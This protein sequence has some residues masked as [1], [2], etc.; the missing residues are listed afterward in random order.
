[1][2]YCTS[3]TFRKFAIPKRVLSAAIVHLAVPNTDETR[4]IRCIITR[5]LD[6]TLYLPWFWAVM[7]LSHRQNFEKKKK[8]TVF[9][10][11]RN[12]KTN[13]V[14]YT[15]TV[16][17]QPSSEPKYRQGGFARAV[18][19][20]FHSVKP[21]ATERQTDTIRARRVFSRTANRYYNVLRV[22]YTVCSCVRVCDDVG[23]STRGVVCTGRFGIT[24]VHLF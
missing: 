24:F 4:I 9:V 2:L 7:A 22:Y 3:T 15:H 21:R 12:G 5:H 14:V 23:L 10:V 6:W 20:L 16:S 13:N 8:K 17:Q 11:G 18:F 19:R 1:M